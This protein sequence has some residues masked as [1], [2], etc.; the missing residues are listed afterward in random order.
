M[1]QLRFRLTFNTNIP[2]FVS[3]TFFPGVPMKRATFKFFATFFALLISASVVLAQLAAGGGAP[4]RGGQ[5]AAGPAATIESIRA[6]LASNDEEWKILEPK[7]QTLVEAWYRVQSGRG[8]G[9]TTT[10]ALARSL[11]DVRDTLDN[12]NASSQVILQKLTAFRDFRTRA[13][14]VYTAAQKPLK[15]LLTIRQEATLVLMEWME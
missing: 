4:A 9:G 12:P 14:A 6:Q 13:G 2:Y 8:R 10:S 7:V 11:Q 3:W 1:S 15:E 5:P